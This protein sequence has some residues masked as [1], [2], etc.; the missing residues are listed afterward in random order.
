MIPST[1]TFLSLTILTT[2]LTKTLA[3]FTDTANKGITFTATELGPSKPN[4]AKV[5]LSGKV[6]TNT[7]IGF[8]VPANNSDPHMFGADLVMVYPGNGTAGVQLA[9]GYGTFLEGNNFAPITK[10]D[11]E[12]TLLSEESS[13]T[14]GVLTACFTRPMIVSNVRIQ[15]SRGQSY[16]PRN[17]SNANLNYLWALGPVINGITRHHTARG[18]VLNVNLF[19]TSS[20][21]SNPSSSDGGLNA[22][23]GTGNG[24]TSTTTTGGKDIKNGAVSIVGSVKEL[25]GLFVLG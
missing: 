17:I 24:S 9:H 2:L 16:I 25:V 3:T 22:G 4:Q 10:N 15:P 11:T 1:P 13:Y 14:N 8:G 20:N 7:W 18:S 5:C 23:N 21:T 6:D 12:V 19:S